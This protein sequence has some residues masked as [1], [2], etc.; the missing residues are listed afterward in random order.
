LM[1]KVFLSDGTI[2]CCTAGHP[3]LTR[4]GYTAAIHLT[5]HD[6]AASIDEEAEV[7]CLAFNRVSSVEVL[8]QSGDRTWSGACP[9][10][11][12][13]NLEVAGTHSYLVGPSIVV[14]NCHH[15]PSP[16]CS[17]V[18]SALPAF[19]RLGASDTMH[20]DDPARWHTIR[21]Q[22]GPI[23][24]KIEAGQLIKDVALSMA[25]SGRLA[26]PHIYLVDI[27]EW[28]GM[29]KK[30]PHVPEIDTEAFALVSGI[31]KKGLYTG[32]VFETDPEAEDGIKR[33][34][35]GEP[36][37]LDNCHH[38]LFDG[39]EHVV[40]SRW[41]LL[42]RTRDQAIIRFNLRNQLITQW[43]KHYSLKGWPTLV[44]CTPTLHILILKALISKELGADKVRILYS[45]H[46]SKERDEVFEWLQSTPGG[47]LISSLVKEGVSLP[48]VRGGVV[49]DYLAGWQPARQYIGRFIRKKPTG[50]N[51]AEV[52]IFVERQHP[53][54]AIKSVQM[55]DKL[56][57]TRG[58][59]FYHAVKG[60]DTIAG[61]VKFE[62]Q[63]VPV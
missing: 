56:S 17:K 46:D 19:F 5:P 20:E 1:V 42:Q 52:T 39:T 50:D 16:T 61:A 57:K 29:F 27:P 40:E 54:L 44:I 36:I 28:A 38:I 11:K 48:A 58:F 23:R 47:V 13:Y 9:D 8:A 26:K 12:V 62:A 34:D 37:K 43:A 4:N 55:L 7:P 6:D 53:K 63:A 25:S 31:W 15:V 22:L 35:D 14:H 49:A 59:T 32:P 60:P 21:G 18:L 30:V 51:Y 45:E 41:C 10:G 33:N 2:I 3:I 24:Y